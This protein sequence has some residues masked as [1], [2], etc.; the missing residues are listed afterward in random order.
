MRRARA[1]HVVEAADRGVKVRV[2]L[3]DLST[4]L[5]DDRALKIRDWQIAV[6]NAHPNI[7]LPLFN[8]FRARS[9]PPSRTRRRI[10]RIS[11]GCT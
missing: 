6:L 2:I 7:E 1:E 4:L 9:A 3:D 10:T 11:W 8:A 5:E